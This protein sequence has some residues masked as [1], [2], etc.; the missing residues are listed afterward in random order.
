MREIN[1]QEMFQVLDE[2]SGKKVEV[3]TNPIML[4][5]YVCFALHLYCI[6]DTL[7]CQ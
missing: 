1:I 6:G 3:G 4:K 7:K 5:Q 2:Y